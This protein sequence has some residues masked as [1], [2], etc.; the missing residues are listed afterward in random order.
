MSESSH[1]GAFFFGLILGA[2]GGALS[3]LLMTPKSGPEIREQI[4]GQTGPVQDRLSSATSSVRERTAD[5]QDRLTTA[6][7]GVRERADD[8]IGASKEKVT[9]MAQRGQEVEDHVVSTAKSNAS[10]S[11]MR[12]PHASPRA[13]DAAPVAESV[14]RQEPTSPGNE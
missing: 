7:S 14:E 3:A 12:E 2:A 11:D 4:M 6:T 8:V 1:R 10:E 9:Q 5:V 13:S